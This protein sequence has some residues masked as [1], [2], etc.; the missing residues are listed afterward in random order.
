MP[1]GVTINFSLGRAAKRTT[2]IMG[3]YID[4]IARIQVDEI[5]RGFIPGVDVHNKKYQPSIVN[6]RPIR[7]FKTGTMQAGVHVSTFTNKSVGGQKATITSGVRSKAYA[8]VHNEGLGAMPERQFF[9]TDRLVARGSGRV[10]RREQIAIAKLL[11][12]RK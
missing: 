1:K 9:P 4:S 5:R 12:V 8:V 3:Q 2:K 7:L 10:A 11:N 6:R